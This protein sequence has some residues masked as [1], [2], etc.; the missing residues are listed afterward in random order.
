MMKLKDFFCLIAG[1]ALLLL[2]FQFKGYAEILPDDQ[3]ARTEEKAIHLVINSTNI[4]NKMVK[5]VDNPVKNPL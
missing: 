4:C 5:I 3:N 1:V 2:A